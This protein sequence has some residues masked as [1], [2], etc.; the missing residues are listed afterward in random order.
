MGLPSSHV[1]WERAVRPGLSQGRRQGLVLEVVL[2]L[3]CPFS[4]PDVCTHTQLYTFIIFF[5]D[6]IA[7]AVLEL[8]F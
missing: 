4:V 2:C 7:L 8:A 6:C 1:Q 3:P 5:Q